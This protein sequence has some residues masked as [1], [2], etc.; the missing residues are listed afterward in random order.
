MYLSWKID[1]DPL[2]NLSFEAIQS[3]CQEFNIVTLATP[4]MF[5]GFEDMTAV[6]LF[7]LLSVLCL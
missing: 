1:M 6:I 5:M 2:M 7:K 4:Q 3:E